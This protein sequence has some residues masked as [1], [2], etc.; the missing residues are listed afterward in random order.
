MFKNVKQRDICRLDSYITSLEVSEDN[1]G[2]EK[3][4]GET[5]GNKTEKI[6]NF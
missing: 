5:S 6:G 3:I 2:N 4:K 1:N